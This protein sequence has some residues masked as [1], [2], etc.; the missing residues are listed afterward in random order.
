MSDRAA[1]LDAFLRSA[2]PWSPLAALAS[3]WDDELA[4]ACDE[5]LA[6]EGDRARRWV[7]LSLIRQAASPSAAALLLTRV[8][9][10]RGDDLRDLLNALT[11]K[12]VVA[13]TEVIL[14]AFDEAE[15]AALGAAALSRADAL[16]PPLLARLESARPIVCWQAALAL[17]RAGRP[18]YG[19]AIVRLLDDARG[20]DALGFAVALETLGDP[21]VVPALHAMVVR[22]QSPHRQAVHHALVRLSG[23]A[24]VV[25]FATDAAAADRALA[26]AWRTYDLAAP[27]HPRLD[28]IALAD[29][30]AT[31]T[32]HDGAAALRLD[33]NPPEPGSHWPR[34]DRAL[35][36]G[37]R[38][39]W[40]AS[41]W[42][43][44]CETTLR[45][46]G[47]APEL[48]RSIAEPL[49]AHLADL[50][51]LDAATLAMLAPLIHTLASG[52]YLAALVDL[53]VEQVVEPLRSWM[54]RRVR[55]REAASPESDETART[56]APA[57]DPADWP[58]A[59]HFQIRAASAGPP[60][61]YGILVPTQPLDALDTATLDRHAAA[62]ATGARPT[63]VA[64]TWVEDRHPHS[65]D[66]ERTLVAAI[67]D[68]HHKL[69]AAA[70]DGASA[71]LLVLA[72]IE[73]S[74]TTFGHPDGA[75]R[76][77]L[78]A[79]ETA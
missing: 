2:D 9:D 39:L 53:D 38:A 42:C 19:P 47:A 4:R 79:L 62:R 61:T 76:E 17:A 67:I 45:Q 77:A 32:L 25:P 21:A 70:R 12:R 57:L 55:A 72:R 18:E 56:G 14:R 44:T 41:S 49:R 52:H 13:P 8:S 37:D 66:T 34:W 59:P 36:A 27:P 63:A 48:A 29:R 65:G 7:L 20:H 3:T 75:L 26:A 69:A 51:A 68:G 33:A 43:D 23:R 64:L 11:S 46:V 6:T 28:D 50:R 31:F 24:P 10:A 78:A 40:N 16:V 22:G 73:D 54:V 5:R 74:A 60:R 58:G 1:E 71:R 30:C 35:W 15:G